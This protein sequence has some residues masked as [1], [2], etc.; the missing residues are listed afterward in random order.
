MSSFIRV[1]MTKYHTLG[2]INKEKNL[3]LIVLKLE[4]P[5]IKG[6]AGFVSGENPLL[7]L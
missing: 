1:A 4:K 6:L 5:K 2:G 7:D 3:F